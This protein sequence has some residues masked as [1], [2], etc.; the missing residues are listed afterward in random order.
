[1][2]SELPSLWRKANFEG[3]RKLQYLVFPEGIRYD[4]KNDDYRTTRINL[5]FS[6]IP[7]LTRLVD[8]YK[9]G[10]SI[11]IDQIPAW[12]GPPGLEPGTP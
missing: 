10:D 8:D 11:K 3:K 2:A 12:V 9:K 5:L 4:R 7:Y 6:G 1:M